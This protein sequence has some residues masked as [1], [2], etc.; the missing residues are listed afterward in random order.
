MS[1][2]P[3][4]P[5]QKYIY[6]KVVK[7]VETALKNTTNAIDKVNKAVVNEVKNTAQVWGK[8]YVKAVNTTNAEYTKQAGVAA[9]IT[10]AATKAKPGPALLAEGIHYLSK[11]GL[12]TLSNVYN[13]SVK[14]KK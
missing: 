9:G 6:D 11:V 12:E 5:A 4:D 3:L 8:S 14:G 1:L 13:S 7:P 2:N 10:A